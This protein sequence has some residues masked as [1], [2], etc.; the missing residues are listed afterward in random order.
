MSTA[1]E[2]CLLPAA[3]LAGLIR[4][5]QISPVD[6]VGAVLSRIEEV[7]PRLNA[8]VNVLGEEALAS[9]RQAEQALKDREPVGA[10][11]GVP[12]SVKDNVWMAGIPC[13][14]GSRLMRDFVPAEDAPTVARLKAAGAI[15]VGRTNTPE[16]AWRGS[17]D[18]PLFGETHNPWD[19]TRTP[20]GSSGGAG[21]AVAAG[22]AP[23]AVGTDGAGSI[24]IP[25]SFCGIFGL[26]PSLGRVPFYPSAGASELTAHI[27]PMTRTVR[28][29]ATMLDVIAG[30]DERDRFSL[31]RPHGGF[32][33]K[34]DEGVKGW[35]IAWSPDLGHIP[36]EPEVRQI[37]AAAV[38]A[39]EDLGAI[40]EAPD[41]G[42]PDPSEM[43][44]VLYAGI[45]ASSHGLRPQSELDQMDPELVKLIQY[46]KSLS[47]VE[48]GRVS[49]H[50][51][52]YWDRVRRLHETY[53][54]LVTPSM[55]VPA[56]ELGRV[57]PPHVDGKQ[58]VHLGWTLAYP[59]NYTGQ[60]A[61]NVP[62]GFTAGGLPVGLQI[63]GRR[64]ADAAVL[65]A[66]AAFESARPWARRWPN[67]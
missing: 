56:F 51:A 59:F 64:H 55:A 26:K 53:D 3:T 19:L 25:S 15:I 36:V 30:P 31:P 58:V 23:L 57:N 6:A 46:G 24:R 20:G 13:T 29:A 41:L 35:R 16:F 33:E 7:N 10:L 48:F 1:T 27:G 17:C 65:R 44:R 62:C 2:L 14:S 11:H 63:V 4:E 38:R 22:L 18:N 40:V 37:C 61:A 28:D 42:L 54:L 66:S 52:A 9:A 47:I 21:A 34:L 8:F 5:R 49:V 12:V 45:Q 67:L 50:R 43:L 32:L 60:P 39:F